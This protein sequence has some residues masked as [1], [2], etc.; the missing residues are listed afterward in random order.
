MDWMDLFEE[1]ECGF[2]GLVVW[3]G[4][5]EIRTGRS[6]VRLCRLSGAGGRMRSNRRGGRG[7]G[8]DCDLCYLVLG[9][10]DSKRI[11]LLRYAYKH[12]VGTPTSTS[13]STPTFKHTSTGTSTSTSPEAAQ[14]PRA[15]IERGPDP[16]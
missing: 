1:E 9:R 14:L 4:G 10:G 8:D 13:A 16:I 15:P 7:R 2:G 6:A 12:L 5:G 11:G 3:W